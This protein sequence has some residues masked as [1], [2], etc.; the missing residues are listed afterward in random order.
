MAGVGTLS[1]ADETGGD[2]SFG[3]RFVLLAVQAV[4]AVSGLA[5]SWVKRKVGLS[6]TID[7]AALEPIIPTIKSLIPDSRIAVEA[8][9][10]CRETAEP[11]LY[12]H[13]QRTFAFGT[14][15]GAGLEVDSEKLFVMSMLHDIGLTRS[16]RQGTDPG[17]LPGYGRSA[18]SCFAVRGAGVAEA[19]ASYADWVEGPVVAEAIC[20]HV[21]VRV[22]KSAGIE[23][24]LLQAAT[25]LDVGGLRYF[26]LERWA[27]EEVTAEWPRSGQFAD[28]IWTA[29]SA[30]TVAHPQCRGAFLNRWG[31]LRK[32]IHNSP[33]DP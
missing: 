21:N 1:W 16:Y 24:H 26:D 25:A 30:E 33:F 5:W 15:L 14:L 8:D 20:R 12:R 19:L 9:Q 32:R 6:R 13:C 10:L 23:A 31:Q 28:D 3:D 2:L 7:L 4:P 27:I 11:W 29:W 22:T 17:S 18:A